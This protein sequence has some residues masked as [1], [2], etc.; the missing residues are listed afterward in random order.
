MKRT[1]ATKPRRAEAPGQASRSTVRSRQSR[2]TVPGTSTNSSQPASAA[3]S[4]TAC[5]VAGEAIRHEAAIGS[6]T[7]A[8]KI[9]R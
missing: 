1:K 4:R 9:V 6:A 8:P 3:P 7:S 5:S 2:S